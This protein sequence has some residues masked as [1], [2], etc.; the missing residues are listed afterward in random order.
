MSWVSTFEHYPA[1]TTSTFL[2]FAASK[3]L[4][5][6][7]IR[8]M[9]LFLWKYFS[10]LYILVQQKSCYIAGFIFNIYHQK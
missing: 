8:H 10:Q 4:E 7:K 5:V 9:F 1:D 2:R 6:Q 3:I